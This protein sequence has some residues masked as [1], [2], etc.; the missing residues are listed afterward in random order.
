MFNYVCILP[1]S[2]RMCIHEDETEGSFVDGRMLSVMNTFGM[3]V[4]TCID[5]F[6]V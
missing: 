3:C 6:S 1:M 5:M 2:V 4:C